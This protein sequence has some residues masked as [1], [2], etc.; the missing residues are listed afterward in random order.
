MGP[1]RIT[2]E[3]KLSPFLFWRRNERVYPKLSFLA[4]IFLTPVPQCIP[5]T[6]GGIA[7]RDGVDQKFE[8]DVH[9]ALQVK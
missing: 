8:K 9:R 5:S 6:S 4:K 1:F 2:V 7:F 3:E